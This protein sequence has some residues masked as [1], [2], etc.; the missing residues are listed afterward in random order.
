[1]RVKCIK[2]NFDDDIIYNKYSDYYNDIFKIGE[3][4]TV[5]GVSIDYDKIYYEVIHELHLL[6]L[7]HTMFEVIDDRVSKYWK[8]KIE[9]N[10]I[11]TLEPELFSS[12][13]FF[14]KFSDFDVELRSK[15]QELKKIML[16]EFN[17]PDVYEDFNSV[18]QPSLI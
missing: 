15:F 10:G 12:D 6:C 17:Y 16:D 7:P 11:I 5:F 14:D 3:E 8:F 1:M 18:N 13:Y 9:T 4:I 2:T